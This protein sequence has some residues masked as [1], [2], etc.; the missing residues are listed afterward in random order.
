MY[1]R[2]D[3]KPSK[4]ISNRDEPDAGRIGQRSAGQSANYYIF[5]EGKLYSINF[6]GP[7][8]SW[9]FQNTSRKTI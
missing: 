3:S 7:K 9:L 5:G 2:K 8:N 1:A 4:Q 6:I